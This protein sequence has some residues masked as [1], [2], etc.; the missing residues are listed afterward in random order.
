MAEA[1]REILNDMSSA[2]KQAASLGKQAVEKASDKL[3]SSAADWEERYK[4][5][6]QKTRQAMDTTTDFVKE[7]P[8]STVLGAAAVGFLAGII[9]RSRRH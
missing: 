9:A 3:Q 5:V 7:H 1:S 6:Q 8:F 2:S 4:A